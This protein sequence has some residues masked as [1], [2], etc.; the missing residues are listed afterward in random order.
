MPIIRRKTTIDDVYADD[1]AHTA[2]YCVHGSWWTH[3]SG[4]VGAR[5]DNGLPCCPSGS[6]LL[7]QDL[8]TFMDS[9]IRNHDHYGRHGIE[10]FMASHNDNCIVSVA[11]PRPTCL[12][13]W[14]EY[15]D[16]IDG[17]PRYPNIRFA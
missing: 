10:A 4:D 1:D 3:R 11:D 7:M 8:E 9:A 17:I 6:P 5:A 13:T 2:W 12:R 16:L 15:N 14:D